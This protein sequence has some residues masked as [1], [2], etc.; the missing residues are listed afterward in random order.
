MEK[1]I[2]MSETV[3]HIYKEYPEIIEIM[4]GLGFHDIVKPGMLH[5]AGK[6]MTIEKGASM[7]KIN[8]ETLKQA[9]ME[10]GFIIQ[11]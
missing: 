3:Y 6:F 11:E 2:K 7:K 8:V 4:D 5:T 9:F 1:V 10:K